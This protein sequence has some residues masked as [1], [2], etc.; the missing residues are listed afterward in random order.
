MRIIEIN[1]LENGA[2]NNQTHNGV[3]PEGW[4]LLPDTVVTENF[5][6]GTPAVEE[7]EGVM[8]VTEWSPGV[9]P[10]VKPIEEPP[11]QLDVIEAQVVYTAM[12]TNTLLEA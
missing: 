8:T 7:V 1:A 5:P 2:H 12:M 10:N 4:A 6:F 11:T 3:L 9:I